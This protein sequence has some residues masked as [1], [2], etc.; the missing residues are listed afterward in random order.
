MFEENAQKYDQWF[1][2]NIHLYKLELLALKKFIPAAGKGVEIGV[3]T[4]RPGS[5][6]HGGGKGYPGECFVECR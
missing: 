2:K 5:N 1:D 3:G 4:G 6:R